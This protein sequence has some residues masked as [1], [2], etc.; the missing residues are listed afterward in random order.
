MALSLTTIRNSKLVSIHGRQ[1][2]L[3]KDD[4][5]VGPIGGPLKVIEDKTSADSTATAF[6]GY[7]VTKLELTTLASSTGSSVGTT[8]VGGA[9]QTALPKPGDYKTIYAGTGHSTRASVVTLGADGTV[10]GGSLGSTF[11]G[12]MWNAPGSWITL[13][14]ITTAKCLAVAFSAGTS[15]ASSN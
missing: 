8:E 13:F 9:Y 15:F 6:V 1:I 7:G 10:I 4:Y 2:A 3:D 12:W 11:T 14:G 5:V